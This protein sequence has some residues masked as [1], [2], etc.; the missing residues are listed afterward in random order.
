MSFRNDFYNEVLGL[1]AIDTDGMPD[2]G[3][4]N[5]GLV[6]TADPRSIFKRGTGDFTGGKAFDYDGRNAV[7]YRGE[8][9]D[10][11]Q[12]RHDSQTF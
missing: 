2:T 8:D 4:G 9:Q 6:D 12:T 5:T 3:G 11:E 10:L 7:I 1:D